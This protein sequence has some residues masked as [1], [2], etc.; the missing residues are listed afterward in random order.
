LAESRRVYPPSESGIAAGTNENMTT[1]L[2]ITGVMT[3]LEMQIKPKF[4]NLST[5]QNSRYCEASNLQ[6]EYD[7]GFPRDLRFHLYLKLES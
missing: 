2:P 7:F 5:I 6:R 3:V 4:L 1:N